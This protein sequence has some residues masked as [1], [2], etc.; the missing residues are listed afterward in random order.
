MK[1]LLVDDTELFLDLERSYLERESF[2]FATARS[3]PEA[4]ESI[5]QN[6]PDLMVLDLFMPGMNGDEV[7]R[8]IKSDPATRSIPVIMVS[9][10][11]KPETR[12][13]C[14]EAGC[15][16]Y[17]VKPLQ[18]DALLEAIEEVIIIAKRRF[19]RI[20]IS[21]QASVQHGGREAEARIHTISQG[22]LFL[23]M[24]PSPVPGDIVAVSFSLSGFEERIRARAQ[25]RW[26][27]RVR[28]GGASGVGTEFVEIEDRH[29]DIIGQYVERKLAEVGSLK[30][31]A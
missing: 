29:R 1:I 14:F 5:R 16:A 11:D 21:L 24:S 23:E 10:G 17:V 25:V 27:G 15:D 31:F 19:P 8:R 3:G 7:C 30:G 20:P 28:A 12:E 13:L 22:G 9:A 4:L 2:T 26:S 6:R 18:R